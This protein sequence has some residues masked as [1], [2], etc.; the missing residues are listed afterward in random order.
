MLANPPVYATMRTRK[1]TIMNPTLQPNSSC[2]PAFVTELTASPLYPNARA[3]RTTT[4]L[5]NSYVN[6]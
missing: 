1:K 3:H 4:S 5:F 6:C 2:F